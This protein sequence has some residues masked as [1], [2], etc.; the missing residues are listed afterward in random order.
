M[1]RPDG[2]AHLRIVPSDKGMRRVRTEPHGLRVAPFVVPSFGGSAVLLPEERAFDGK[3]I[4][5]RIEIRT[6]VMK[7][8]EDAVVV[9]KLSNRLQISNIADTWIRR[10]DVRKAVVVAPPLPVM[11]RQDAVCQAVFDRRFHVGQNTGERTTP[12]VEQHA[13]GQ[14][15]ECR[16]GLFVHQI[17][18]A[19]RRLK[20]R[21]SGEDS[22]RTIVGSDWR[23]MMFSWIDQQD[24][25]R[26]VHRD[27]YGGTFT[28]FHADMR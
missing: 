10:P 24:G 15:F 16:R 3:I 18:I 28:E 14:S 26:V 27:Q 21:R 11:H 4:R 23:T 19:D 20:R 1:R 6:V 13:A 9:A 25:R 22:E 5:V 17:L 8:P 7:P 2:L 12:D